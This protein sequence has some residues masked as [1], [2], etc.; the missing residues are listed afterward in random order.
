MPAAT[1]QTRQ[2][3]RSELVPGVLAA[4]IFGLVNVRVLLIEIL[5]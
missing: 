5:R 3:R 1:I 2:P 4:L